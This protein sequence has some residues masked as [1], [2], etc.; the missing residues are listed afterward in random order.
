MTKFY[1]FALAVMRPIMHLCFSIKT[2]G[3]EN[4]PD[5]GGYLFV[6]NHRS[7]ADPI[8][9]PML[10]RKTAFCFIAKQELFKNAFFKKIITAL[11]AIAIDRGTCDLSPLDELTQRLKE[12]KNGL[13][14]PEG[15]RSKDG[16]LGRFK[17]GAAYIVAQTGADVVPV[18]VQ[19]QNKLRFRSRITVTFGAPIHL[20]DAPLSEPNPRELRRIKTEMHAAVAALLPAPTPKEEAKSPETEQIAES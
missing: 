16:K 19:F 17:S 5:G 7:Y 8:L 13:I 15:T 11:G 6:S 3:R 10:E 1:R 18:S 14:F 12:G 20:L 2:I 9:I 4:L